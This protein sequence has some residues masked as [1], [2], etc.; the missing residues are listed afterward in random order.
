MLIQSNVQTESEAITLT[1]TRQDALHEAVE[2]IIRLM[3]LEEDDKCLRPLRVNYIDCTRTNEAGIDLGGPRRELAVL[4][5]MQLKDSEYMTGTFSELRWR[6][7]CMLYQLIMPCPCN[8]H[9]YQHPV[10][11]HTILGFTQLWYDYLVKK[12]VT[13]NIKISMNCHS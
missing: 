9:N 10:I 4:Y 13:P 3:S 5:A 11:R 2:Q 7:I 12:N 6:I 1:L 8:K